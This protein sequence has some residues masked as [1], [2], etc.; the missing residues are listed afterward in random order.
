[1]FRSNNEVNSPRFV[2]RKTKSP[3]INRFQRGNIQFVKK[4]VFARNNDNNATSLL[5][6]IRLFILVTY[7]F[8]S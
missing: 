1:M 7:I 4:R 2:F 3:L 6:S 8:Y 5:V